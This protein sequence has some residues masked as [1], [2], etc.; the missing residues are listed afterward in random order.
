MTAVAVAPSPQI[1][2]VVLDRDGVINRNSPDHIRAIRVGAAAAKSAKTPAF[3][4]PSGAIQA[5][6]DRS[7]T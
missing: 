6:L 5:L 4:D 1:R 3:P 2:R 7:G